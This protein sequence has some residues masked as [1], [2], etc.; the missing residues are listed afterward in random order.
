MGSADYGDADRIL[1]LLTPE[2]GRLSAL[3]RS[4]RRS[5]KRFGGA[6]DH[7]NRID[8]ALRPGAGSLW[9]LDEATLVDGRLGA[10]RTLGTLA[11][12]S[13]ATEL[14]AALAREHHAEPRLF[15]L[16]DTAGLLLSAITGPPGPLFRLA[17][18]A[19]AL[20]FAGLQPA[21]M[22]CA[23]CDGPAEDP[24]VFAPASGGAMHLACQPGEGQPV[25]LAW[26]EAVEHGRRTPL[27]D[28][29]DAPAPPGP[30]EALA[31]AAEAH[32][33]A[34]LRSRAVLATLTKA[35]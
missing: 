19:K 33:N 9:H 27:K 28:L 10:R 32:M 18:E 25:T 7:G 35:G 21:L 8:A 1:R 6:L 11:L 2:H 24:M 12:L 31:E 14:C 16:L 15:G 23:A 26:L 22:R 5:T 13:Y 20:T 29:I 17:L 30:T 34:A 3:A 4:A